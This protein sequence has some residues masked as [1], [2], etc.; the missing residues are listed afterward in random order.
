MTVTVIVCT[1]NRSV[2]L[3]AKALDSVASSILP[4]SVKWEVLVVDNNSKD[5]TREVVDR[6]A[7]T[8]HRRALPLYCSKH[9]KVNLLHLTREFLRLG[10]MCWLSWMTM[11]R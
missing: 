9:V 7:T 4:D 10:V 2:K 1:F 11:L 8:R 6:N 5:S 3:L